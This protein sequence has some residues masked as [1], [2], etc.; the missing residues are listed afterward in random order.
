MQEDQHNA[1]DELKCIFYEGLCLKIQGIIVYIFEGPC[2]CLF[3]VNL[4][5]PKVWFMYCS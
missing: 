5:C 4:Q 1:V 3:L 2:I